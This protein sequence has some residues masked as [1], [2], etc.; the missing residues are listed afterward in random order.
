MAQQLGL[1]LPARTARGRDSFFAAPSNH[2]ALA[3]IDSW[4]GWAQG[5]LVLTGPPGSGKT[6]LAHVWADL[7][8]ASVVQACD[9]KLDALPVLATGPLVVED[10]SDI[11]SDHAAEETLF[12]L[13]N[14]M[15]AEGHPL[16]M[17]GTGPVTAWPVQLPDLKSRLQGTTAVALD[18][19]DDMLLQALMVK[20][21]ADRQLTPKPTLVPYL[22]GRI[23]RSFAAAIRIIEQLDTASIAGKRPITRALAAQVLDNDSP[24]R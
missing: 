5:K 20:L 21:L 3:M 19:P 24:E 13:H 4:T 23:E 22:M 11:A 12:H 18:P 10:I 8:G 16:L 17:T 6:H 15:L 7:T 1:N 14:L 9:L 2:M